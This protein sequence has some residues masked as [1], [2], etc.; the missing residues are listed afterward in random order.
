MK[1]LADIS[2]QRHYDPAVKDKNTDLIDD[3]YNPC[4]SVSMK[5]DRISAYFNS[6][7]LKSFSQGLHSFCANGGKIRF[8]FSCQLSKE[9]ME[10]IQE[11]YEK[12]MDMMADS[13]MESKALLSSDF[14]V[15]NLAYLIAHQIA[16][17]K[18]A[19]MLEDEA[20][21]CHIKAGLFEDAENN[22]VYFE[23]SGNE[24]ISGTMRN[25]ENYTVSCSFKSSE[26]A[27]DANYGKD[28]F[29]RIWNNTYSHTVLTEFP[30]GRLYESLVSFNKERIYQNQQ[31][32]FADTNSVV[33]DINQD[34]KLIILSD[35]TKQHYLSFS[36]YL[37]TFFSNSWET[38]SDN[39]YCIKQLSLHV[40]RDSVL[41]RLQ[42]LKINVILTEQAQNYLDMNNLELEKRLKL[43]LAIKE[44]RLKE[45]WESDF[46]RFSYIVNNE[47]VARLKPKQMKNAFFHYEMVS[48]A[49][50]SVP[51]TGKTY[52]AYGLYAYLSSKEL[53]RKCNHLVVFGPI[54]CFKAWKEEGKAIFGYKRNLE[55][56]DIQKHKGDY[57]EVLK[58]QKYD[59]YLINYDFLGNMNS[60]TN[61]K[62]AILSQEVLNSSSF[63]VFDEIHKLKSLT[64]VTANNFIKLFSECKEKPVYRL[65]LTGT[66]LPNSF[67]DILNYLKLLYTDDIFDEFSGLTETTLKNADSDS[68]QADA[69]INKL[70]PTFVRTTK[71]DLEVPPADEDDYDSLKVEPS[72]QEQE[73]YKLIW[74]LYDN[75]LLKFIRLIQASSNPSLLKER[76]EKT[77]LDSWFDDDNES[78]QLSQNLSEDDLCINSDKIKAA[79]DEISI[80]TK[81][82]ATL[83]KI[84]ELVSQGKKVLVWCL[85]IKT[86]SFVDKYLRKQGI[87]S[88]T[89][90]GRDTPD[91]RDEKLNMFRDGDVQVL[92]TNPNT[93]AESVSLHKVCHDAIYLEYG[94]NLTYMLQSKDRIHRVGL[95]PGT[96]THYYYAI[97]DNDGL[98]KGSID[99]LIINRLSMKTNRMLSVIESG[100]LGVIGD[101]GSEMDDIRYIL[102]KAMK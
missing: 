63:V 94:F 52:I 1:T 90:C 25:A 54:N 82:K 73:L 102:N 85:F 91:M 29:E 77:E 12:R 79:A 97:T 28:K 70:L 80:S 22:L 66:P 2:I 32:Y 57:H 42:K 19:F 67:S 81:M 39:Y 17:V 34:K 18:I 84:V 100:K 74:M 14:E 13:I 83:S 46:E 45:V 27:S 72:A 86:I 65:A 4:L 8:I 9:D 75:S 98:N 41:K 47:M 64:G 5:Y 50:Y 99:G 59:V 55:I 95:Q 43:G 56:F 40:L 89:I 78:Q 11:G 23:G 3:F 30:K 33:I 26:Q 6:A 48:S 101:T 69:V 10:N 37:K 15:S 87:N 62:L 36:M 92:I 61:E 16:D 31:E 21:I 35:F 93:L 96:H 38:I 76:I 60:K 49:D 68:K 7:V 53:N 44:D 24:T 20:S 71:K 58:K 51:G 88:E